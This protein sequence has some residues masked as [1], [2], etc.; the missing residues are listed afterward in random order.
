MTH[1]FKNF[2]LQEIEVPEEDYNIA[3]IVDSFCSQHHKVKIHYPAF[4]YKGKCGANFYR[5]CSEPK[6]GIAKTE[7]NYSNYKG[8]YFDFNYEEQNITMLI[9]GTETIYF[10]KNNVKYLQNDIKIASEHFFCQ[11]YIIDMIDEE[12]SNV[13]SVPYILSRF[14]EE[15][16]ELA[17][18]LFYKMSQ[19]EK[20]MIFDFFKLFE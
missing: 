15:N 19:E 10:N 18:F 14:S 4:F 8:V 5:I 12:Y 6:F 1:T 17:L 2:D 3:V 16:L 9:D 7:Q 11:N 13:P 20:N